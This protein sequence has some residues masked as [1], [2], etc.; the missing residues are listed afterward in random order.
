M[1]IKKKVALPASRKRTAPAP[2]A[3]AAAPASVSPA[4][5]RSAQDVLPVDAMPFRFFQEWQRAR[6]RG[7]Y[8]LIYDLIE[9]GSAAASVFGPRAEFAQTVRHRLRPVPGFDK[10]EFVRTRLESDSLARLFLRIEPDRRGLPEVVVE[11]MTIA[12]G[13]Q[14]WR[15]LAIDR[16]KF[17]AD[18]PA[19]TWTAEAFPETELPA[20]FA[21]ESARLEAELAIARLEQKEARAL[22][23]AA[24]AEAASEPSEADD[25]Q[26]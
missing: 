15:L 26:G 12:R 2:A 13:P 19:R 20:W 17:P 9:P 16:A 5:A 7:E 23:L 8:E 24:L 6:E 22:R 11:R 21:E 14:G 1:K 10:V 18:A 3:R 25:A 4:I